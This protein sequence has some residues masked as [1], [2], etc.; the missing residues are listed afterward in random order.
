MTSLLG[1]L[2]G[3]FRGE[4]KMT[5]LELFQQVYGGRASRSGIT[6]G[7]QQ[8]IEVA[9][10]QACC[11]VLANG[12]AQVPFPLMQGLPDR[13][14]IRVTD[15]PVARTFVTP[16]R[17]QTSF[18]LR[19]T[20]MLHLVLT[21][22]AFAWKGM[23]GTGRELRVLEPIEPNYVTVQKAHDGTV[24]YKVTATDGAAQVFEATEIWHIRGPAWAPWLG[25]DAVKLARDAIGLAIATENTQSDF[26]KNGAQVSGLLAMDGKIGNERFAFLSAWLDRHSVTGDRSGKPLVLDG[27]A[28]YTPFGMT[29]VDAQ[30]LETRRFQIE[31]ICRAFG[32]IPIMVGQS[33]KAATYASAEQMFLSHVVHSLAP[34]YSR[35]EQSADAQLLSQANRDAGMYFKFI[36]NGLLRGAAKDRSAVY[37]AALGAAGPG[38]AYMTANEVRDLE[39]MDPITGGD[40]LPKGAQPAATGAP[41]GTN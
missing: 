5:S 26:H 15:H 27:N 20:M 3:A 13:H 37:S 32:V 34:W 28:K 25:M 6:V 22:N 24:T 8:A 29:G 11:R 1:R 39:D 38:T 18:A 17:W 4:S 14:K 40:E 30:Q 35:I 36:P 7:W 9:V 21:G 19:E 2:I 16:N 12:V 10:V 23:V 31:E 41:N 33:D